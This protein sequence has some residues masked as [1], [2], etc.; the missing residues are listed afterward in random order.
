MCWGRSSHFLILKHLYHALTCTCMFCLVRATQGYSLRALQ[1]YGSQNELF[2]PLAM[3][4]NLKYLKETVMFP[5]IYVFLPLQCFVPL[6]WDNKL[7]FAKHLC[8]WWCST[9]CRTCT[10]TWIKASWRASWEAAWSTVTASGY[11]TALWVTASGP[12]D[13]TQGR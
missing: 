12:R 6:L 13:N 9:L 1:N 3:Q 11:I 7:W 5:L 2:Y 10:A 8:R 4:L